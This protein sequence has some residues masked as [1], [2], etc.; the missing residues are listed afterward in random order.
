MKPLMKFPPYRPHGAE[1]LQAVVRVMETGQL[2]PFLGIHDPAFHG[3]PCLQELERQWA[4]I[5]GVNFAVAFNSATSAL[6]AGLAALRVSPGDEVLVVGYSMCISASAP[7]LLDAIPV[8]V[9]I[10]PDFFCMDP[11]KVEA[12]I[13][14]R[15]KAILPVDL[16]GQSCDMAAL[17]TIA[18]RHG[19][20]IL[21]DA[22]HAPGCRA[23]GG[24]TGT[25]GDI[26]VFSLNQH[27]IIH[28][29]EGGVA[30]TNDPDL[31]IRLK[32]LR[33]HGEAVIGAMGRPDLEGMVGG[34]YRLGELEAA[35]AIE[36]LKKLPGLISARQELA[37]HL[38]ERLNGLGF[39]QAPRVRKDCEHVYY[40]FPV[41]FDETR[42]GTDR[43]T[44]VHNLKNQGYELYRLAVGYVEPLHLLPLF[45][46]PDDFRKGYPWCLQGG[47]QRQA[48]SQGLLPVTEFLHEKSMLVLSH[49]YPPLTLAHMDGIADAF[50]RAAES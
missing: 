7:L 38:A 18:D 39:L 36:Q 28:C 29:G 48:Y 3:G 14:P 35:I 45:Q 6:I 2:S 31:A 42:A 24:Y 43:A 40:L 49:V 15:T 50:A 9:D 32:L 8:F 27:K 41:L 19:L 16:F 22:S 12:A 17:K 26:G 46:R 30:V 10:E 44:F 11:A 23:F 5:H 21:N 33:N 25:M 20:K 37:S 34:N 13:T 1:E 47:G 4:Q